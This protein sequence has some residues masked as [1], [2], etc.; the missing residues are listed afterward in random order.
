M[1]GRVFARDLSL[2]HGL[3]PAT[4]KEI[5][6][7]P[8]KNEAHG[9]D[10]FAGI[11]R[12]SILRP[13]L[14]RPETDFPFAGMSREELFAGIAECYVA[15][16]ISSETCQQMGSIA[17][18]EQVFEHSMKQQGESR[19]VISGIASIYNHAPGRVY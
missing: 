1:P 13:Y 12:Q 11:H 6:K 17:A 16:V 7:N 15:C 18:N 14:L 10:A 5:G 2:V 3:H 19:G 4:K 8:K 9:F